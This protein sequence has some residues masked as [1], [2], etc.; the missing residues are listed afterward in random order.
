MLIGDQPRR[1][2]ATTA[3]R[4][5]RSR[6]VTSATRPNAVSLSSRLARAQARYRV[7]A[8]HRFRVDRLGAIC[9]LRPR[10]RS[11]LVLGGL[12]AAEPRLAEPRAL[13]DAA[14]IELV[15]LPLKPGRCER[16]PADLGE[17]G[18]QRLRV[19]DAALDD[20]RQPGDRKSV[21]QGKTVD[22]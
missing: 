15:V 20:H 18:G 4:P 16:R 12:R 21:V 22:D 17:G 9:E 14:G 7:Y 2:Q 13:L 5:A 8:P 3:R 10:Q 19:G 6:G 1:T 11:E